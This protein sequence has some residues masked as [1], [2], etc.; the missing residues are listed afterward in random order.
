[1]DKK[2]FYVVAFVAHHFSDEHCS[3]DEE[4]IQTEI[5][6]AELVVIYVGIADENAEN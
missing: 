2:A 4:V 1:M 5:V 3:K 6:F